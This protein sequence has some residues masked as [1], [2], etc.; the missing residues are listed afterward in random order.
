ML[1]LEVMAAPAAWFDGPDPLEPELVFSTDQRAE[2]MATGY[3]HY[4]RVSGNPIEMMAILRAASLILADFAQDDS[5]PA[6]FIEM[7]AGD[8]RD[9]AA[10]MVRADLAGDDQP[11]IAADAAAV[12]DDAAIHARAWS[13]VEGMV[14]GAECLTFLHAAAML[15][16]AL[17]LDQPDP[18][19]SA[20]EMLAEHSTATMTFVHDAIAMRDCQ[21]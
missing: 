15:K 18:I 17:A 10:A 13:M 4:R 9:D 21:N 2:Y 1:L 5:S 3:T 20:E 19:A 11:R 7:L 8:L 14:D 16:A 12:D 6:N